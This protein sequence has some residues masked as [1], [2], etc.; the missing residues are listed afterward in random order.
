MDDLV[1]L[2]AFVQA[3]ETGSFVGAGRHLGLTASAVGKA[4]ARLEERLQARLLH[5]D[6]RN[7]AL[8]EAGRLFLERC[9][10]I[11]AEFDAAEAELSHAHLA[12][13]G[14]LRI[15]LPL[16]AMLLTPVLANF[17]RA[18]PGIQLDLDFSDRL[19]DVI[20]EGFDAVL[21]TG[22]PSDSGLMGRT[23]GHFRLMIVASPAYLRASGHPVCP[24]DLARHRCL[25]QRSPTTGKLRPWPL[26]GSKTLIPEAM[27]ATV[28]D[29]LVQLAVAGHGIACL[30]PF[31][32]R[33]ALADGCLVSLLEEHIEG[34]DQFSVLW[35]ASRQVTAKLRAFI[36]FMA[37]HLKPE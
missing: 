1:T 21:R 3:A 10:R 5:R 24:A 27:S 17:M 32:V 18:Y 15:S 4:V 33:N 23:V 37:V 30:P 20:E 22:Q 19:V 26:A 14:R 28:I 2:R 9:R 34:T 31:A 6:T 35:P 36:D 16:V 25:R 29:P 11:L 8:T 12:P 13:Q 7:M